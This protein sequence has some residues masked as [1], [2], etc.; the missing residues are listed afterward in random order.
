MES[1]LENI[2]TFFIFIFKNLYWKCSKISVICNINIFFEHMIE[3][4]RKVNKFQIFWYIVKGLLV[5]NVKR[6][7]RCPLSK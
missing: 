2:N 6:N 4:F 7:G 3:I 1:F 5:K